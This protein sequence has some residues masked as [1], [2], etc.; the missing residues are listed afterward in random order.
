MYNFAENSYSEI[1]KK[2]QLYKFWLWHIIYLKDTDPPLMATLYLS[3][4]EIKLIQ[5]EGI[6][7]DKLREHLPLGI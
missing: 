5:N 6:Q 3:Q 4:A 7:H 1:D 2:L